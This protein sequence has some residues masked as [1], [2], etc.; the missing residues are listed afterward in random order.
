RPVDSLARAAWLALPV[1]LAGLTHVAVLRARLLPGL[2]VPLDR[3]LQLRGRRLFGDN[4]TWRGAI[5]MVAATAGWA[6]ALPAPAPSAGLGA[7]M[8]LG[9]VL[10]E[11]PNSLVK[12]QLDVPPGSAARGA[13]GPL[14][15]LVD[16]VDSLAAILLVL[17]LA[18][19]PPLAVAAWLLAL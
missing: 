18:E 14:F 12:R 4:K 8:G 11:L 2:A 17:V 5:V 6:A 10:G 16:Q 3:G 1:V 15:W 13:A 19:P 7:L 9:Y